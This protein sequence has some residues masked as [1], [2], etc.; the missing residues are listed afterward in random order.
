MKFNN[1]PV[2]KRK[3]IKSVTYKK[4]FKSFSKAIKDMMAVNN[5][6]AKYLNTDEETPT[7]EN[8]YKQVCLLANDHMPNLA[9]RE[10]MHWEFKIS[11]NNIL[12]KTD[13]FT[14]FGWKVKSTK[15]DTDDK[16]VYENIYNCTI[17]IIGTNPEA[18]EMLE[19]GNW[20]KEEDRKYDKRTNSRAN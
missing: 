2:A 16:S 14:S 5:V 3:P 10:N 15:V 1:R 8:V 12:V 17:T 7:V 13:E 20:E 19:A 9:K 6:V 18:I 4:S 11:G